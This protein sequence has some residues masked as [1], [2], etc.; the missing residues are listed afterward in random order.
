MDLKDAYFSD[1]LPPI[2][3]VDNYERLE[4]DLFSIMNHFIRWEIEGVGDQ[5]VISFRRI[6]NVAIHQREK[7]LLMDAGISIRDVV[8]LH[9]DQNEAKLTNFL[10]LFGE[11][12][13]YWGMNLSRI[14]T[15]TTYSFYE[16][17][18]DASDARRN[19]ATIILKGH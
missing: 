17:N 7:I 3:W 5:L 2:K 12:V 14:V 9:F 4:N 16:T 10:T 18:K 6:G 11:V 1:E 13:F 8:E 19:H 15:I